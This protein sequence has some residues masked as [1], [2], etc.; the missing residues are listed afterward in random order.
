MIRS[1]RFG[2]WMLA[3]MMPLILGCDL[4]IDSFAG[5]TPA[6]GSFDRALTVTG[7]VELEVATG[8]G[9]IRIRSGG[10]NT[11][12]VMGQ[13]RVRDSSQQNAEERVRAI[14]ADP[15]IEQTGNRIRIGH[16]DRPELRRNV[17]ISY[18]IETP[19]GTTVESSTGSGNQTLEA[20]RGPVHASTGS[21]SI[22]LVDIAEDVRAETGSGNITARGLGRGLQAETGSG[23]IRAESVSGPVKLGTGSGNITSEQV[24]EGDAE[25]ETG[26]GS[27]DASGIRG[28]LK[29]STGSG[30]ITAAGAPTKAWEAESGSGSV[31]VRIDPGS[32]FDID[33][34]AGSG[35]V[36]VRQPLTTTISSTRKEIRG[37]VGGGGPQV[38]LRSSSGNVTV[39]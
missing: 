16:G 33:A 10:T 15:P 32:A 22:H 23:S 29:A 6:E 1:A 4:D 26:S 35:Q 20:V 34:H 39:E 7:P 18:E 3:A 8:S 36:T 37:K 12:R 17:S 28:A 24:A 31:R 30:S 38:R 5:L 27:I 11:V 13:I 19:A 21:G 9:S 2:T 14:A 25:L